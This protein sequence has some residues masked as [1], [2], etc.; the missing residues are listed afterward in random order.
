MGQ[1]ISRGSMTDQS[2]GAHIMIQRDPSICVVDSLQAALL[3]I[4]RLVYQLVKRIQNSKVEMF[5]T[6]QKLFE[7]YEQCVA[8]T[9]DSA[10]NRF[11]NGILKKELKRLQQ[12][13]FDAHGKS[14][15]LNNP[16]VSPASRQARRGVNLVH[17][18]QNYDPPGDLSADGPRHDNDKVEISDI[19]LL[20]TPGEITSTRAPFLPSNGIYNAPHP[21]PNG[22]ERQIDTHFRLYR[23]D[24]L[25]SL[26]KG[27]M[28]FLDV[29]ANTEKKSQ[30]ILLKKKELRKYIDQDISLNVYGNVEI[31]GVEYGES[32]P[33]K[34]LSGAVKIRFQ[35][36]PNLMNSEPDKRRQFWEK[37]IKRMMQGSLACIIR[38]ISTEVD[39][40]ASSANP[41]NFQMVLAVVSQRNVD[42]LSYYNNYAYTHVELTN[43][44]DY[45]KLLNLEDY[46]DASPWYL[47]ES[48][49]GFLES[50]RPILKALQTCDPLSLPF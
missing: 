21:L 11:L 43:P 31:I 24:M 13:V 26:R 34:H 32:N 29:L 3:S 45:L 44:T 40:N 42:A 7:Q 30:D 47:V 50:Y 9:D 46:P 39:S 22:W 36:P 10:K 20:P 23:E 41:D 8:I 18:A 17:L 5:E 15:K 37:S 14:Q 33:I 25:E 49:G 19:K 1:L 2:T 12:I 28:G 6:V 48:P 4:A 16:S 38:R 35:Q 27:M